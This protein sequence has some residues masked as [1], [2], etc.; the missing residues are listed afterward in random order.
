M[1]KFLA[2]LGGTLL[3]KLGK[4]L[5]NKEKQNDAQAKLNE[6]ELSDAPRSHLRLWRSLLGTVL[7]LLF[8]WEVVV[9]RMVVPVYFPD[10]ADSLLQISQLDQV[11][12]LLLGML[13][14]GW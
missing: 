10:K 3:G 5:P 2:S 9:V 4:L 1:W 7:V 14:I 8:V 12:V 6:M 11:M 13:G